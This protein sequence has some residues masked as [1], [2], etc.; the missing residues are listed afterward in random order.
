MP[1][2]PPS[3][4][5]NRRRINGAGNANIGFP[6]EPAEVEWFGQMMRKA[7]PKMPENDLKTIETALRNASFKPG[8]AAPVNLP[9]RASPQSPHPAP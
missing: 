1:S 3:P 2:W 7:A 6:N 5:W 4:G 9:S 8:Q